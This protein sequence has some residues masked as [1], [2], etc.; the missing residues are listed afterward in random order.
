GVYYFNWS[1]P[2]RDAR[3]V[4]AVSAEAGVERALR[5]LLSTAHAD[6][7]GLGQPAPYPQLVA[8]QGDGDGLGDRAV[9]VGAAEHTFE[10]D[11]AKEFALRAERQDHQRQC[12]AGSLP[13]TR[14]GEAAFCDF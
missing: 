11:V 1:R 2:D 6:T 4:A 14:W 8:V 10:E 3:G 13:K 7:S 5:S 12:V 9:G